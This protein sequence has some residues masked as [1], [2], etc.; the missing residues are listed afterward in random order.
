MIPVP[1]I[2][3]VC[4]YTFK[5]LF[6]SLN[7]IYTLTNIL[8]YNEAITTGV[9]FVNSLYIPAG[10][11][12]A[13][14]TT[15]SGNYL[16]DV[17]LYLVPVNNTDAAAI[18]TPMSILTTVPD[19]MVGCYNDVAIGVSLGLIDDPTQMN[20]IITELTNLIG[21]VTGVSTPVIKLYSLGT[22]YMRVSDYEALVTAR[23]AA[24]IPYKTLWQQLQEQ[25]QL[26]SEAQN[27]NK[28]Y[29]DTLIALNGTLGSGGS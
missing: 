9:D 24:Q 25:I 3:S 11:T 1:T 28:Y 19:P 23:T 8:M 4:F 2:N 20:W 10:S 12:A 14:F 15:D 27:L 17:V 21:S 16:N 29:Q 13:Q 6:Q 26:T 7:G 18:Y 22:Q 5:T